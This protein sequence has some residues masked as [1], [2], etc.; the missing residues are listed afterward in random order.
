MKCVIAGSDVDLVRAAGSRSRL[1]CAAGA[2]RARFD[3]SGSPPS[4]SDSI[5]TPHAA[6]LDPY[7]LAVEPSTLPL[8]RRGVEQAGRDV[9]HE[10]VRGPDH[11]RD[12]AEEVEA[13]RK[14][15]RDQHG[16]AVVHG[17]V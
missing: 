5:P 17:D 16:V 8:R 7:G 9:A 3:A 15:R 6:T 2:S 14:V 4:A 11:G 13:L 10:A 1:A 12:R